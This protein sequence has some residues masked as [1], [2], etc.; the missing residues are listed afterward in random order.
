LT[1]TSE[2]QAE[3]V[4][5]LLA[6]RERVRVALAPA[7]FHYLE[8][9]L[10]QEGVPRYIE[11]AAAQA[12]AELGEPGEAFRQL[13]DYESYGAVG[14]RARRKLQKELEDLSLGKERRVSFYPLGAAVALVLQRARPDWKSAYFERP[15]DLTSLFFMEP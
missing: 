1:A 2:D 4:R 6:E 12:A 13:P 11:L 7:D 5:A 10:W 3:A 9:Q 8:F 15:F 14:D